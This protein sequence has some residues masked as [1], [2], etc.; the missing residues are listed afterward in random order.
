MCVAYRDIYAPQSPPE[1]SSQYPAP[2][3]V[4][5]LQKTANTK[6]PNVNQPIPANASIW[7]VPTALL[8]HPEPIP[9][10]NPP[11]PPSFDINIETFRQKIVRDRR[12]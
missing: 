8:F 12:P 5:E 4:G 11:F 6:W 2:L 3:I 1:M 7:S 9:V 10:M